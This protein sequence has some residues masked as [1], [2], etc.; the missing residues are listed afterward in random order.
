[1]S[2]QT[3]IIIASIAAVLV[4]II[5]ILCFI[6]FSGK[7]IT[8]ME[9]EKKFSEEQIKTIF[10]PGMKEEVKICINC[11][12]EYFGNDDEGDDE[13]DNGDN[14]QNNSSAHVHTEV[15]DAEVPA[16]CT[17]TG[18][19]EGR[20][21][22][23]C[24]KTLKAQIIIPIKPHTYDNNDDMTCNVCGF[25]KVRD[26]EHNDRQ[27]IVVIPAKAPS[28]IATGLTEGKQCNLC[29]TM[30][31]PQTTIP[32][33]ECND[34]KTLPYKEPTCQE[35][36]LTA[37]QQCNVCGKIIVAQISIPAECT[38]LIQ[39]PAKDP[40]CTETGLTEGKKCT[41]CGKMV[42]QQVVIPKAECTD[43]STLEYKEPTCQE[44]GL[45]EGQ[46]CDLCGKI[47]V[48][49]E[50]LPKVS[51]E[52]FES[53]EIEDVKPS[54]TQDGKSHTECEICGKVLNEYIHGA[55]SQGLKY[56]LNGDDT[57]T[58]VGIGSCT[59]KELVIPKTHYNLP[60]TG[61]ADGAFSYLNSLSS[62]VIHDGITT[63]SY[64]AFSG[65]S[66]LTNVTIPSTV[67]L[68]DEYAFYDCR[69]LKKIVFN[70]TTEQWRNISKGNVWDYWSGEYTV[71]CTNGT[72]LK[73]YE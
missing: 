25:D 52:N 46:K 72:I 47:V 49:Q 64:D 51:C 12:E 1:M 9:C 69:Q 60:V 5:T 20:H 24:G 62:V 41:L 38:N 27:Q 40:T 71:Y 39:V 56:E 45:T 61:I 28:C 4:I 13:D 6:V 2:K 34:L 17:E 57:Y 44:T 32:T 67:T 63:I 18:L 23:E 26:C 19:T 21:C 30:I 14:D 43:L 37:G 35:N 8:C 33:T 22:S 31:I 7:K 73:G 58:V 55:G 50:I 15:I 65:C 48:A 10:I 54:K 59:D 11:Y 68:I 66:S 29:G 53:S 42:V 36:G 70:G 16:T 3:K